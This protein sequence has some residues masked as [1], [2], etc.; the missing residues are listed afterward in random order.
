[1]SS[2]SSSNSKVKVLFA[3]RIDS[4]EAA[5][6]LVQK[7]QALN[8]S[9]AGPFDVAFATC[10]TTSSAEAVQK[11]QSSELPLP[12]YLQDTMATQGVKQ[13]TTAIAAA[14]TG[15]EKD[16]DTEKGDESSAASSCWQ[17]AS[18]LYILRD[19]K[20][21]GKD[22]PQSITE[23]PQAG[24]WSIPISSSKPEFG[25]GFTAAPISR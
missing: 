1:M 23:D 14:A 18:N 10:G 4:A 15:T 9:K 16:E 20:I 11:L 22:H 21:P 6:V 19:N 25:G 2:S 13:D 3:G 17:V 24:I 8:R 12:L 7:L 5:V